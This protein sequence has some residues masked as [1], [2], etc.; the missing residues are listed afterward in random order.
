LEAAVPVRE[1]ADNG[2]KYYLVAFDEHGH[3]RRERD[4]NIMSETLM[5]RV[6]EAPVTDVLL[7][8]H[9]WLGDVP[10]AIAQYD[11][12]V[13]TMVALQPDRDA[14]R[15]KRAGFNPVIV[16]LHWPSLPW[17]DE[18]IPVG[19]GSLLL[20]GGEVQ[21]SI[22]AHV[23]AYASRIASTPEAR[24][25]IRS[26][27]EAA[28]KEPGAKTLSSEIRDAY[29]I[30]F[31]ESGLEIGDASGRPGADQD[32]FDPAS[33]ISDVRGEEKAGVGSGLLGFGD[34]LRDE[35]L[36]PLRQ[37][38][39]WKMKDRARQFG[40]TG[41]HELL[42]QL[43]TAAPS[44]RFHLMG[45]SFGCIVVSAAVAGSPDAAAP[46]LPVDSLFLVQGALSLWS[47]ASSIPYALGTAGYF[48]QI[49]QRGL[50]RG[51]IVTTRSTHD[52]AVG[53]FYPLGA[54]LKRQF[55]LGEEYPQ[56]GGTGAFGI[57]GLVSV[58]DM[59][60]QSV[61]FAYDFHGGR[62]Y[63]IEA[64]AIIK[65]G[66]GASGAHSDIAHPEVAHVF[67][68][69]VLAGQSMQPGSLIRRVGRPARGG[70][71]LGVVPP[72]SPT[73]Q[74]SQSLGLGIGDETVEPPHDRVNG[75]EISGTSPV[76]PTIG[77]PAARATGTPLAAR[78]TQ[79][80]RRVD[81]DVEADDHASD[82]GPAVGPPLKVDSRRWINAELEDHASNE[83]LV[84]GRWYSL[85]FDVDIK[86]RTSAVAAES[87]RD[88]QLF[89]AGT[90]EVVLT[91]QVDSADFEISDHTRPLRLARAGKGHTKAR[92]D[93]SP[94][95]DGTSVI[96][97]TIH[98]DGNF[99]QQMDLTFDVGATGSTT[100]ML[101]ARGRP[102]SAINVV[103][104]RDVGLSIS[105]TV[106]GYDCV[107][108]GAVAA[109][110]RLPLQSAFLAK[111]IDIL[112]LEVMKVVMH[113][114]VAGNYVFQTGIDIP[115]ADRDVVLKTMARAGAL[116]FQKMFFGPGAGADSNAV[117][118]FL[119]R[120]ASDRA[121]RLK[122]QIMAE[123]APLPWGLLYVGDASANAK[124]DWDNFIGM[125]HV[126]EQIPLQNSLTVSD[127]AITSDKPRLNV[128]L[129]MNTGIDTQMGMDF[130]AQQQSFWADVSVSRK[131]VRV[132]ERTHSVEVVQALSDGTTED[133]IVYFYCHAASTGLTDPGGPDTS[134]LVLTDARVTLGDLRLDAPTTTQLRGNPLVFI[135]ACESAEMSP[136]FYDGFV[137]YFMAKGA[138]GVVGTE[139]KTPAL[140]AKAWA[141]RFFERFLDGE[142]LGEVFLDLRREF[143]E[144]HGN[145][146]GLLYAVHCDCDT[147]IQPA[148]AVT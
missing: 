77:S 67:W 83:P 129:N 130:V 41:S 143:L 60:M 111:S 22:E 90:E 97:T 30:L 38:S 136:A 117:G 46:P 31:A 71:L 52:T 18:M 2:V 108:W 146:L 93:I 6:A 70:G 79:G 85:A 24:A 125:R 43:Q 64:S 33:I 99:I 96:K 62:V 73:P 140:F 4:G 103:H 74:R 5:R 10:A 128:S 132:T 116:L 82:D 44:A 58:D 72:S 80:N 19:G 53:R 57:R 100:V 124:L 65:S 34:D 145:P 35:V 148:L 144:K 3:E 47:Y 142:P 109:R 76:G 139:C 138:R 87:L 105:P 54:Q 120:M 107:V 15:H 25:A 11:K 88:E 7:M 69:A 49:V 91:V 106:G 59:P 94:Q 84:K 126:I 13:E 75:G 112:R 61:N 36:M 122:L 26:I 133:Q 81:S 28:Y 29:A 63:N 123:N 42:T 23:E 16:G 48:H 98:K 21:T 127:C 39:F 14:A 115:N 131:R 27:L 101:T 102:S 104:P 92:F 78:E 20:T 56:Y 119:R 12:W 141:T 17:G 110:A 66:V 55:V 68:A 89:P 147:Q 95:H 8:S 135:N 37:L 114:D 121:M 134:C 86:Q 137:P 118:N 113:Q 9:G 1:L 40:E 51:P 50:V 45:H 32:G